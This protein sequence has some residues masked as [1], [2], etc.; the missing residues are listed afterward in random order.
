MSNGFVPLTTGV[1]APP[2]GVEPAHT[3]EIFAAKDGWAGWDGP[4]WSAKYNKYITQKD[5]MFDEAQDAVNAKNAAKANSANGVH[6]EGSLADSI[7]P[8]AMRKS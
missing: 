6:N 3:D 7:C 2:S 4:V 8:T 1:A 5:A